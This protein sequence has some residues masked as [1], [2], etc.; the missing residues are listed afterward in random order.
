MHN[1]LGPGEAIPGPPGPGG[2][3]TRNTRSYLTR[4]LARS[5]PKDAQPRTRVPIP[6]NATAAGAGLPARARRS[7]WCH[8]CVGCGEVA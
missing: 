7:L 2:A 1:H 5:P 4:M 8:F 6:A 3:P